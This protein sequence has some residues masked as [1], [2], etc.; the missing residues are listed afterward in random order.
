MRSKHTFRLPPDLAVQLADYASRVSDA[1][2]E[3]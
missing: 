1:F 3:P 2:K